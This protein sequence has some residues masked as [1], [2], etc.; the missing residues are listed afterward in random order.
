MMADRSSSAAPAQP[1]RESPAATPSPPAPDTLKAFITGNMPLL[2]T[3]TVLAGLAGFVI[4][5]PLGWFGPLLRS[6]L[7]VL[8]VVVWLDLLDQLPQP[9]LLSHWR[10]YPSDYSWRLVWF[11]YLIQ[12]LMLGFMAF[13]VIEFPR[14]VVPALAAIVAVALVS[15]LGDRVSGVIRLVIGLVV[16]ELL[17]ILLYPTHQG[18]VG[19][20]LDRTR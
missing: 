10:R 14:V 11:A 16:F 15:R 1:D 19:W 17:L 4:T 5:L 9:L 13:L 8:S 3:F 7:L 6:G 2:T 18:F 12:L 20:L